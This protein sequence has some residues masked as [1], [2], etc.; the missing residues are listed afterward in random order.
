MHRGDETQAQN[1][2]NRLKQGGF[3]GNS[4]RKTVSQTFRLMKLL[5]PIPTPLQN[6]FSQ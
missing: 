5:L 2:P 1:K 4:Q 6:D 3:W